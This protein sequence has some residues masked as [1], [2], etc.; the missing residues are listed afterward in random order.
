MEETSYVTPGKSLSEVRVLFLGRECFESLPEDERQEIYDIH[1]RHIL[2]KAR[3]NFQ[4]RTYSIRPQ[5]YS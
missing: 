3:A 1:Q 5:L 4:V 2:E